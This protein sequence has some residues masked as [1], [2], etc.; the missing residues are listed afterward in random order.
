M[1]TKHEAVNIPAVRI[2]RSICIANTALSPWPDDHGT[3]GRHYANHV[4][5]GIRSND[6]LGRRQDPEPAK[7]SHGNKHPRHPAQ[8]ERNSGQ[9][10]T[11]I[12]LHC[13]KSDNRNKKIGYVPGLVPCRLNPVR[14]STSKKVNYRQP[15]QEQS[16]PTKLARD[17]AIP[18]RHDGA[19]CKKSGTS[20]IVR[21]NEN[22]QGDSG[23]PQLQTIYNSN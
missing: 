23:R 8:P 7:N 5:N 16:T 1:A 15:K 17:T 20:D 18:D 11:P 22:P 2:P 12:N 19:S 4:A 9:G 10:H 14:D 13:S 6:V 21:V 3:V